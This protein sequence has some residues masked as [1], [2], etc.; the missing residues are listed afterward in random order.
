MTQLVK[1]IGKKEHWL[2]EGKDAHKRLYVI[3]TNGTGA[4]KLK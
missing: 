3:K 4:K 1:A 2:S